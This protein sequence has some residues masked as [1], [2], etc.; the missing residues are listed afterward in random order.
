MLDLPELLAPARSVN[1]RI[2]IVC[3]LTIDLKPETDSDVIA[4]GVFGESPEAPF[5][6]DIL[7]RAFPAV[8]CGIPSLIIPG[9]HRSRKRA[10]ARSDS[11]LNKGSRNAVEW[12][13]RTE[14]FPGA[15]RDEPVGAFSRGPRINSGGAGDA[16][17]FSDCKAEL[18]GGIVYTMTTNP[19]HVT[20]TLN[21]EDLFRNLMPMVQWFIARE[22][23]IEMGSWMPIPDIAV[24]RGSRDHYK[25]KLPTHGEVAL[26]VEVSDTTYAKDRGRKYRRYATRRIPVYWIVDLGRSL[27]EVHSDPIGR[28]YRTCETYLASDSVPVVIDGRIVGQFPVSEI[29]P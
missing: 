15:R 8:E 16:G 24:V 12:R 11:S 2:S 13:S 4:G 14:S 20:A 6:F 18:L 23:T 22:I 1:G 29:L 19:P 9:T 17:W 5:D 25:R 3:S 27:V 21:L 26:I 28:R 7:R 10:R